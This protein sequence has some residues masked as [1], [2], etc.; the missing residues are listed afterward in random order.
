[1]SS[2]VLTN[3]VGKCIKNKSHILFKG[4]NISYSLKER[5]HKVV[6]L[7]ITKADCTSCSSY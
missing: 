5:D 2:K 3:L 7:G 1:M 6:G 4:I